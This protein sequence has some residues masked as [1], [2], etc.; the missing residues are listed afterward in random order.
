MPE[1]LVNLRKYLNA[2][3]RE[4]EKL[5]TPDFEFQLVEIKS[6]LDRAQQWVEEY[7]LLLMEENN[8]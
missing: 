2:A 8:V 5:E 7:T 6:S 4:L 3:L 1:A